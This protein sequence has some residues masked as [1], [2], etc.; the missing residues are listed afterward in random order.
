MDLRS[1]FVATDSPKQEEI[2]SVVKILGEAG[3]LI[4][5]F[6]TQYCNNEDIE[7]N[8]K[9]DDSPVTAADFISH[10][11]IMQ[12]LNGLTPN[13]P[14]LS[15]EGDY[16]LRSE[17][18]EFWLLDPLD[19]T[20]EFLSKRD[21]FTINL[22]RV[23]AGK[24]VFSAI[25]AP[26]FRT[27]YIAS[28]QNKVLKYDYDTQQ[29]LMFF[30]PDEISESIVKVAVSQGKKKNINSRVGKYQRYFDEIAQHIPVEIVQCGSA[31]KFCLM[32]EGKIDIYPRFHPTFEWDTSAGQYLLESIG[33]GLFTMDQRPFTYNQRDRLLNAEFIA[34][35][36]LSYK[37]MAFAAL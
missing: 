34:L 24:T 20:K 7:I 26:V 33:G 22:S 4:A 37:Q 18:D 25:I 30:K 15:E 28:P 32:I 31:Y 12:A 29:W 5:K 3:D 19:G 1:M 35:R 27:I 14:V 36:S 21:E 6:Y 16:H 2:L 11:H 23:V 17:W 9:E 10:Q 13:I 8:I